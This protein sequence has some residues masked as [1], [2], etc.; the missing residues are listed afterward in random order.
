MLLKE[1]YGKH[2]K[3]LNLLAQDFHKINL[4]VHKMDGTVINDQFS[5]RNRQNLIMSVHFVQVHKP[6]MWATEGVVV[7]V[8][9]EFMSLREIK[10]RMQCT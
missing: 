9:L 6:P 3:N 1:F 2:N 7:E 8:E 10:A 5:V 4:S